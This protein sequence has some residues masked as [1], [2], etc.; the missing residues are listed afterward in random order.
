[1]FLGFHNADLR[2]FCNHIEVGTNHGDMAVLKRRV[3]DSK[4]RFE[5]ARKNYT[6]HLAEHGC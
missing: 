6:D 2:D 1:M 4:K 3:E 5:E